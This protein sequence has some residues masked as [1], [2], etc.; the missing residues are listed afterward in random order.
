M[1]LAATF[2]I[3]A[4]LYASEGEYDQ[5]LSQSRRVKPPQSRVISSE[6]MFRRKP[7]IGEQDTLVRTSGLQ[8]CINPTRRGRQHLIRCVIP[9]ARDRYQSRAQDLV[10]DFR[11]TSL[12]QIKAFGERPHEKIVRT[13]L[14]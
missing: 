5:Q 2:V 9:L 7:C 1:T 14:G 3:S 11:G 6:R 10:V 13:L 4:Q 8:L 12:G